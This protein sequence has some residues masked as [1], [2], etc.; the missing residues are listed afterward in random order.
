MA[1]QW[2]EPS[3]P[4]FLKAFRW[5]QGEHIF[6]SAQTGAGKTELETK[7]IR[8]QPHSVIFVTKPRDKIFQAPEV[9][10]YKRMETWKPRL[11]TKR[12]LLGP[13]RA[14]SPA[15]LQ[16]KQR[17]SFAPAIDSIYE[18][19]GWAV[20]FDEGAHMSEFMGKP[21]EDA[22]KMLHHVGRAYGISIVFATQ[23]PFRIPVIV[24]ESAS[25]AFIGRTSRPEDLRRVAGLAPDPKEAQAA[26]K[27]LRNKHDFVYIDPEGRMPLTIVNTR[28]GL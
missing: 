9:K 21:I 6:I 19:G 11:G 28:R 5:D 22:V 4:D 23:R 12:I 20:G 1:G 13:R 18:D 17:A 3:W 24:P 10:D 2:P 15:D 25:H 7:V 27:S 8:L 16:A 14:S 26:I